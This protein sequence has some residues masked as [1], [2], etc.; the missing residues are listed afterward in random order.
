MPPASVAPNTIAY[1]VAP[2][3]GRDLC[4][5]YGAS[6]TFGQLWNGVLLRGVSLR[7]FPIPNIQAHGGLFPFGF[8]TCGRN[9]KSLIVTQTK[10][11]FLCARH[12][13]KTSTYI[14]SFNSP[15]KARRRT[16]FIKEKEEKRET[17]AYR[18]ELVYV[19]TVNR[20]P[21]HCPGG[22]ARRGWSRWALPVFQ[23][24]DEA[25][26]PSASGQERQP[27]ARSPYRLGSGGTTL[28]R[29]TR[30]WQPASPCPVRPRVYRLRCH[31]SSWTRP[32]PAGLR[33]PW[34]EGEP[35]PPQ[36]R[37]VSQP[38]GLRAGEETAA[39]PA[40]ALHQ[41]RGWALRPLKTGLEMARLCLSPLSS[42]WQV[43]TQNFAC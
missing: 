12:H 19:Y 35:P 9:S 22:P 43:F 13:G 28:L 40:L 10:K 27:K 39:N 14:I 34:S 23:P 29:R 36:L 30:S 38:R 3:H 32:W 18:N 42:A 41:H 21:S 37:S 5:V 24:E 15:S 7:I 25:S 4:Y 31:D 11:H 2:Q 8:S 26:C 17:E 33:C 16:L 1:E 20:V 6:P